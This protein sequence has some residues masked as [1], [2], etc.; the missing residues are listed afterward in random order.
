MKWKLLLGGT[1]KYNYLDFS[2]QTRDTVHE[3]G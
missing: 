1:K 3:P 2:E